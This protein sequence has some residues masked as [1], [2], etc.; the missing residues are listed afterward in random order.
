MS[1]GTV[2]GEVYFGDGPSPSNSGMQIFIS[3]GGILRTATHESVQ[4][5]PGNP[6]AALSVAAPAALLH[7]RTSWQALRGI[8]ASATSTSAA[9]LLRR[10]QIP[11][12]GPVGLAIETV[13]AVGVASGGGA[14]HGTPSP[15]QEELERLQQ[16]EC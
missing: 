14:R 9:F 4:L 7:L 2:G 10:H 15:Q 13:D 5:E 11:L 6:K 16:R 1:S 3:I 8:L 12:F